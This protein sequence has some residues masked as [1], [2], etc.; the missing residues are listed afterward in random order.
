MVIKD[1]LIKLLIDLLE[2]VF[3]YPICVIYNRFNSL[4]KRIETN[5]IEDCPFCN[6]IKNI[7]YK[8]KYFYI[9]KNDFPYFKTKNHL[10]IIPYRHINKWDELNLAEREEL[11]ELISKYL[12][13]WYKLLWRHYSFW[14]SEQKSD[15]SVPHLHIHLII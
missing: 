6:N 12:D 10:L 13:K 3:N 2:K 4:Y 11:I 7:I 1:K 8:W 14:N 5:N 15:A 9:K